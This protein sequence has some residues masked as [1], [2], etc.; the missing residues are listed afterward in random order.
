M[1]FNMANVVRL[2]VRGCLSGGVNTADI[3]ISIKL[4]LLLL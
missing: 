2:R 4:T 3:K 1:P